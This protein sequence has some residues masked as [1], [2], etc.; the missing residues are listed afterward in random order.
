MFGRTLLFCPSFQDSEYLVAIITLNYVV[1][2]HKKSSF[3][4]SLQNRNDDGLSTVFFFFF[5][6]ACIVLEIRVTCQYVKVRYLKEICIF[7]S[8]GK[9]DKCTVLDP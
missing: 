2:S 8:L 4:G 9:L 6:L 5:F 1:H 7:F 3:Q